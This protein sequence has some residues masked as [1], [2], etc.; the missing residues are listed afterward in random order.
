MQMEFWRE[1]GGKRTSRGRSRS[2]D[3]PR[4]PRWRT[5]ALPKAQGNEAS[6]RPSVPEG[7]RTGDLKQAREIPNRKGFSADAGRESAG[8]PIFEIGSGIRAIS[9]IAKPH[10]CTI[11]GCRDCF[12]SDAPGGNQ[13]TMAFRKWWCA[14]RAPSAGSGGYITRHSPA[15]RSRGRWVARLVYLD[16]VRTADYADCIWKLLSNR[17]LLRRNC[18]GSLGVHRGCYGLL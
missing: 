12:L 9:R 6:A 10:S 15:G 13:S 4:W 2:T 11:R 8:V 7:A 5:F 18:E 1:T 14:C 16:E 3:F 17:K